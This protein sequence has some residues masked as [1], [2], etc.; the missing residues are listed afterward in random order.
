VGVAPLP[1]CSRGYHTEMLGR[2]LT[3]GGS[4][5]KVEDGGWGRQEAVRGA[6]E[7]G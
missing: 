5:D 3:P 7:K 2:L 4:N 1:D 6:S